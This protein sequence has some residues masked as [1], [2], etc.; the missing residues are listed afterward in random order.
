MPCKKLLSLILGLAL[1]ACNSKQDIAG[2]TDTSPL[3]IAAETGDL[4]A[5][6]RLTKGNADIDIRDVCQWTPLMKAALNG[7]IDVVKQLIQ[8]GADVNLVDKGGYSALM[9]AASN[10][11][12][13]ILDLL[14]KNDANL[15]QQEH[16][17][18][19]TALIWAAKLGHAESVGRLVSGGANKS[20]KDFDGKFALDW[21]R[22]SGHGP[23]ATLLTDAE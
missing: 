8:A 22:E 13:K 21:A 7:H 20:I 15:D 18:G 5:I 9:L 17:E 16:T 2:V 4:P 10:N 14:I 19:S 11:H 1:I 23:I 6:N 12:V 3:L